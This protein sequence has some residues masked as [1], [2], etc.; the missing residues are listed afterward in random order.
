[1]LVEEGEEA[2]EAEN[3]STSSVTSRASGV[4][5]DE[6]SSSN[7]F[8]K[9]RRRITRPRARICEFMNGTVIFLF[10]SFYFSNENYIRMLM[11]PF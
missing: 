6:V 4:S 1:M 8:F 10:A 9:R 5:G 3:S 11:V 7:F 2:E